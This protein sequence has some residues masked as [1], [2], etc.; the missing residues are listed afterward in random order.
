[1]T[2]GTITSLVFLLRI[3]GATLGWTMVDMT[4]MAHLAMGCVIG[5]RD[6]RD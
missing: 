5:A 1:L 2:Y 3:A 4:W 6:L